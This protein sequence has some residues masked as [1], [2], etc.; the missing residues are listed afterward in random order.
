MCLEPSVQFSL[1]KSLLST[2]TYEES[3]NIFVEYMNNPTQAEFFTRTQVYRSA[4]KEIK[5]GWFNN[6]NERLS[7]LLRCL[8]EDAVTSTGKA[9]MSI[10]N[11]LWYHINGSVSQKK[12]WLDQYKKH[13][14]EMRSN[15]NLTY[16]QYAKTIADAPIA[17]LGKT[18][19]VSPWIEG[20]NEIIKSLFEKN[21]RTEPL[22][23]IT[24]LSPLYAFL[25]NTTAMSWDDKQLPEAPPIWK[26]KLFGPIYSWFD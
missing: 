2:K 13:E 11:A 21:V 15:L 1:F 24:S 23:V 5:R 3:F 26:L 10:I 19:L 25:Q 20:G 7:S 9:E 16:R 12:V 6:R 18:G 17:V 4:A 14:S 22:Q 8:H